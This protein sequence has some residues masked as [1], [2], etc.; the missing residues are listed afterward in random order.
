[1]KCEHLPAWQWNA[2]RLACQLEPVRWVPVSPAVIAKRE[3][4]AGIDQAVAAAE[5]Q[6]EGW[7]DTAYAFIGSGAR[8]TRALDASGTTSCRRRSRRA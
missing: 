3:A 7:S 1:V 6:V 4:Q 5:R 8:R 2:P